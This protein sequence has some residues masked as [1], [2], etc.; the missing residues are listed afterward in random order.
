MK[1]LVTGA[2]GMLAKAVISR[3][4]E[5]SIGDNKNELILTDAKELDITDLEAVR[6]KVNEVRPEL[7]I[8]CAAYTNVDGAELNEEICRKVNVF[9]PKNLAIAAAEFGKNH[10]SNSDDKDKTKKENDARDGESNKTPILV[11]ISTDYV[12]GGEKPV[13]FEE[14]VKDSDEYKKAKTERRITSVDG[15]EKAIKEDCVFS[16]DDPKNPHSVYGKTKLEAEEEIARAT[17]RYYIFRT[18]WLYGEGKNFVRTMIASAETHDTVTVVNDQWGSPTYT[19]DLA[20]F[21]YKTVLKKAPFG[22]YNSTDNG[23]TNWYEF[24]KKIYEL[25][26]IKTKVLPISSEEYERNAEEKAREKGE[27]RIVAKRPKNSM[28]S[29]NKLEKAGVFV[30]DWVDGLERYLRTEKTKNR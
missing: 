11:H 28:L 5:D 1:I 9:G 24:T 30:P 27:K 6:A 14:V 19:E 22:I 3:F 25:S 8:N 29:K 26:G 7:I 12:F 21:I 17:D 20:N 10:S 2:K 13:E 15:D 18:A 23:F 4:E 16:E